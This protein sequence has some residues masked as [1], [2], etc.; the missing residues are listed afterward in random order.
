MKNHPKICDRMK[1]ARNYSG[2]MN[3]FSNYQ[4][5]IYEQ[6][7]IKVTKSQKRKKPTATKGTSFKL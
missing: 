6:G 1:N 2:D 4:N 3:G 7:H 5:E